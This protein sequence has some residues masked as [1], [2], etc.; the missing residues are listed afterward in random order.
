MDEPETIR[1]RLGVVIIGEIYSDDDVWRAAI[2]DED[3]EIYS[4][5]QAGL[6]H[7]TWHSTRAE[8]EAYIMGIAYAR[9]WI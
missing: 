9:E 2:C 5:E 7:E 8:A 3:G 4:R 6:S 1:I